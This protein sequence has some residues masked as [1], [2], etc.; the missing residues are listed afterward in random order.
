VLIAV[1]P[2]GL[3][4]WALV[5]T[6]SQPVQA[7]NALGRSRVNWVLAIAITAVFCGPLSLVVSLY[8]LA[9]IRPQL[10]AAEKIKGSEFD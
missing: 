1:L 5:D 7:W 4:G 2:W 3:A 9:G 8:Y 6:A 10:S